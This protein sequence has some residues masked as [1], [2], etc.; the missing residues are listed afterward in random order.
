M[1]VYFLYFGVSNIST[2]DENNIHEIDY[3]M[4]FNFFIHCTI[5]KKKP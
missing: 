3:P 2:A 1:C 5:K 4:V